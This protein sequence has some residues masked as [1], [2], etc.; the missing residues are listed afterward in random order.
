MSAKVICT[1]LEASYA[2]SLERYIEGLIID[3]NLVDITK[4]EISVFTFD[5]WWGSYHGLELHLALLRLY[6]GSLLYRHVVD[7]ATRFQVSVTD[8]MANYIRRESAKRSM[9]ASAVIRELIRAS[10]KMEDE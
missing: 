6:V 10:I 9:S 2:F 7:G 3:L 5:D 1:F 4:P 8:E